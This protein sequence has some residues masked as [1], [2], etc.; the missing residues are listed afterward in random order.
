MPR[1][2]GWVALL[3]WMVAA[4][5]ATGAV[6]ARGAA[7]TQPAAT[8]P[9]ATQP[10]LGQVRVGMLRYGKHTKTVCFSDGFLATVARETK[11]KVDRHFFPVTLASKHLFDWPFV[12]MTG[13][14]SFS[15]NSHERAQLKRYLQQGGFVLA[16][17]GCSAAKWRAS[18]RKL[19]ALMFG[20]GALKPVKVSDPVFHTIFDIHQVQTL[21]PTPEHTLMGVRIRGRLVVLFSPVG[22]ND[23]ADAGGGCC[24][25][26]GNELRNARA[27]NADVLAYVLTH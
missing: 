13:R 7:A 6:T 18:F 10:V 27:I 9:A 25:C 2:T 15:L 4:V 22:L 5:A 23:T 14:G 12:V 24:C 19:M 16:S 20:S 8:Q 11:I 1:V 26:G 3:G 21:R 17:A